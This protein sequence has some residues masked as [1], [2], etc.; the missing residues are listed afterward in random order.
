MSNGLIDA[1]RF[2]SLVEAAQIGDVS[3]S[4]VQAAMLV[5]AKIG[6]AQDSRSFARIFDSE[7]ALVLRDLQALM[8]RGGIVTVLSRDART[9]RT[10]YKAVSKKRCSPSL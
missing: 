3:L 7:H 6:I 1:S 2:L 5:A 10:H 4:A 9:L 8:D